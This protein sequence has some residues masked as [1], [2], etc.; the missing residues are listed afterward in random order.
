LFPYTYLRVKE[1]TISNHNPDSNANPNLIP[2]ASFLKVFNGLVIARGVVRKG[3]VEGGMS[4]SSA[5]PWTPWR[6]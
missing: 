5:G 4:G 2:I 1:L 6:Q 3:D